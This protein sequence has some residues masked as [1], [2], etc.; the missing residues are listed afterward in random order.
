MKQ[1]FLILSI[2]MFVF[3]VCGQ[4]LAVEK[5]C[6]LKSSCACGKVGC[7]V[8]G[9]CTCTENCC[10]ACPCGCTEQKAEQGCNCHAK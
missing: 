4:S 10:K 8:D 1:F 6:C 9:K 3:A 2:V 5:S 7:L